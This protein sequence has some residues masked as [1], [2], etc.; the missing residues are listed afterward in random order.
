MEFRKYN[1][2]E[3]T[4]LKEELDRIITSGNH[5]GEFVVQEKVHGANFS[6]WY[7]GKTFKM[8]KRSGFLEENE[9]FYGA[10]KVLEKYQN[11]VENLYKMLN[12]EDKKENQNDTNSANDTNPAKLAIFGELFGGSYPHKGV[13]RVKN[14]QKIQS[15]VFYNPDIDFYVYDICVNGSF[16][17]VDRCNELFAKNSFFYAKTLFRGAFEEALKYPNEFLTTIPFWL[18]LP[19]MDDPIAP[20][21]CEGVVIKPISTKYLPNGSRIILKNK[22]EKWSEKKQN[23]SQNAS[24]TEIQLSENGKVLFDELLSLIT[25]NRLKNVISKIGKIENK[26]FGK[27]M[28]LLSLDAY[29]DFCKSFL[30]PFEELEKE[31]QKKIKKQM[32]NEASKLVKTC[33]RQIL[34]GNF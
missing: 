24:K 33:F 17:S 15:G 25:E 29:E 8:A 14:V 31:E 27:M 18:D 5:L 19:E 9:A 22:N 26:D 30:I 1:S 6:I 21:I 34:E 12:N 16:L 4:Y 10:Q 20:N 32:N 11:Q 23:T 28:G 13:E 2:L 3:N 7:D